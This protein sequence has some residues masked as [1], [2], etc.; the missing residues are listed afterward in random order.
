[1]G[2]DQGRHFTPSA[3]GGRSFTRRATHVLGVAAQGAWPM[4]LQDHAPYRPH[5]CT[6][7]ARGEF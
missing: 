3:H 6:T 1:M 7:T 4:R 5:A 2:E